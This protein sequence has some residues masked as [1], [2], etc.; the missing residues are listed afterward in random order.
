MEILVTYRNA[1][2]TRGQYN[3]KLEKHTFIPFSHAM[4]DLA[5]RH[6]GAKVVKVVEL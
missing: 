3:L 5:V 6:P 2:K 1:D 4:K